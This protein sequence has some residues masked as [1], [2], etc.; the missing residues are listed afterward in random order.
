MASNPDH[1][2]MSD[3]VKNGA[4]KRPSAQFRNWISSSPGAKHPPAK[5]RYVLYINR[6]CP[7][8]HRAN[9]VRSLK[10][11]E[12]VVQLV[13]MSFTMGAEG[14]EYDG[15]HGSDACDPLHGFKKHKELYRL[16]DPDYAGR[17][18][19]PVL[20]DK[21]WNTIVSNESSEIIRMLYCE[22]DSLLPEELR[23]TSKP[24]G[25]LWPERLRRE[26][27]EMNG[28]VYDQINN[29]VYKAGFAQ[30]Q[31]PYEE[32][33]KTLFEGLDRAEGVLEKSQGPYVFGEQLTEADI[34][35]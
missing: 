8:A 17:F 26:I 1:T 32:A 16:A 12:P 22:F 13:T 2:N 34:R 28:W 7:W 25:G 6:G 29:G 27:E 33:V 15:S 23:E 4:F 3:V 30:E 20:W 35:L 21:E 24:G 10:G 11:L 14:W 9:L 5:D 31:E 19:V 18:T